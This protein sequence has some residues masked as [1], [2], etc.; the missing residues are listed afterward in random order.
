VTYETRAHHLVNLDSW[1]RRLASRDPQFVQ[2]RLVPQ[3][4]RA[5][6][7]FRREFSTCSS[8]ECAEFV[9][10]ITGQRHEN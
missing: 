3:R 8:A 2:Y 7:A 1:I 10:I 9:G 4:A 5:W 6:Q